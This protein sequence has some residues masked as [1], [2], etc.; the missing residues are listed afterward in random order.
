M[1]PG[2]ILGAPAVASAPLMNAAAS[3]HRDLAPNQQLFTAAFEQRF[4]RCAV[5]PC[6][7]GRPKRVTEQQ[8]DGFDEDRFAAP[9]SPVRTL[10]PGSNSPRPS[11]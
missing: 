2:Q 9:V 10:R 7:R 8:T 5:S 1:S 3:L 6:G 11:R 4:D